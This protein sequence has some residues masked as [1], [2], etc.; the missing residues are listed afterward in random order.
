MISVAST[1]PFTAVVGQSLL[2]TALL[3]SIVDLKVGGVLVSGPRGSAKSTVVRGLSTLERKRKLVTLPLGA[4]EDMLIGSVNLEKA[5]QNESVEFAPG[6]LA[7]A[8]QGLLYVDE[9][10]L[11]PD[12]LVDLLL[13]VA[14]SG[15]NTVERDGISHSHDARF[16]LIGTMNPDE[17]ELRAQLLDRFGLMVEVDEVFS[18]EQRQQIV[19]RRLEFDKSPEEFVKRYDSDTE[20]LKQSLDWAK[21]HLSDIVIP[22]YITRII[23]ERC[24]Y[25]KVDGFRADITLYRAARAY[26]GLNHRLEVTVDDVDQVEEMVFK[27]RRHSKNVNSASSSNFPSDPSDSSSG[28]SIQGSWG[29]MESQ[30]ISSGLA[31]EF[32]FETPKSDS[33]V[34]DRQICPDRSKVKGKTLSK[35]AFISSSQVSRSRRVHWFRTLIDS[36]NLYSQYHLGRR[37]RFQFYIPKQQI[38]ELDIILLDTSTSTLDNGGIK[39]AKGLI[40]GITSQS[41]LSRRRL[42]VVTFGNERVKT[43]LPPQR[44]PKNIESVLNHITSGGGTPFSQA[45]DYVENLFTKQIFRSHQ[46][47]LFILTDGRMDAATYMNRI[48]LLNYAITVVD[49]EASTIKLG[50]SR[51]LAEKLDAQYHHIDSLLMAN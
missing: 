5:L 33:S 34:I 8:D 44:T 37:S 1:Y 13:D 31:I 51:D 14:A 28:S 11:L 46:C 49:I 26:A 39:K 23:A 9:V 45:M 35:N 27:H 20:N 7:K 21:C 18:I 12:H 29:V 25:A 30:V 24:A 4:T 38:T 17:G 42:C 36:E 40:K 19:A 3:V 22:K 50:L 15:V 10:N 41:Y 2:K 16:V 47:H 6:L 32:D 48:K 43:M